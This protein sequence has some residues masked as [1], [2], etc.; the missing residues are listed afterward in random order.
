[1]QKSDTYLTIDDRTVLLELL[2]KI[3][4]ANS[5]RQVAHKDTGC[6][7]ELSFGLVVGPGEG[8]VPI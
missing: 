7:I 8:L 2:E 3:I 5:S 1:M 6:L 4:V